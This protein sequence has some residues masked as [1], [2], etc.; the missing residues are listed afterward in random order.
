[1]NK[2]L[3]IDDLL[4]KDLTIYVHKIVTR[5]HRLKGKGHYINDLIQESVLEYLTKVKDTTI[6]D[7][8][9]RKDPRKEIS[10]YI[11][12]IALLLWIDKR[13]PFG[14]MVWQEN[15][16]LD[17]EI[18]IE[19]EIDLDYLN[20][21][22]VIDDYINSLDFYDKTLII[23]WMNAKSLVQMEKNLHI[24]R[25]RLKKYINAIIEY[26]KSNNVNL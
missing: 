22:Q 25:K 8:Q 15:K 12:G 19:D 16:E 21:L 6:K 4:Y 1:M 20:K 7:L 5:E 14:K 24:N 23:E 26:A 2:N 11:R 13:K 17:F 10:K 3:Y 9:S 18:E